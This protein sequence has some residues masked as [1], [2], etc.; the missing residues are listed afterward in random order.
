[1]IH[2]ALA[3]CFTVTFSGI[4][5]KESI[6]EGKKLWMPSKNCLAKSKDVIPRQQHA[7]HLQRPPQRHWQQSE[8]S[9]KPEC[10]RKYQ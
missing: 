1:V 6:R 5:N 10:A 9:E 2:N 4:I 3:T 7:R 8:Q